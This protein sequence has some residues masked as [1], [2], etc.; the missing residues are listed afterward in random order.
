[1]ENNNFFPHIITALPQ[2]DISLNGLT[3][4]LI[5]CTDHQIVFMSF[6]EE[7]RVAEH[8]HAAQ[9]GVVLS[10]KIE[11]TINGEKQFYEKGDTYFIPT[12]APHSAKVAAGYKDLT[13]FDEGDRYKQKIKM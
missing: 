1:M 11:L 9:W 13:L 7:A 4:Y 8:R 3:S 5:Q 6:E 2:A 12:N 10:G